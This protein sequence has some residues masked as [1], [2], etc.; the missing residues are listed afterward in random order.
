ME[1]AAAR[2]RIAVTVSFG[3]PMPPP[4]T[5]ME[6]RAAVQDLHAT[7]FELAQGAHEDPGPRV[8]AHGATAAVAVLHGGRQDAESVRLVRR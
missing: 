6:V 2:F 8:C 3:K 5:A 1:D 4:S 7:A